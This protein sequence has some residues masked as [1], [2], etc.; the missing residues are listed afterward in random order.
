V[1]INTSDLCKEQV[2]NT[3]GDR[4]GH[5]SEFVIRDTIFN[6][7]CIIKSMHATTAKMLHTSSIDTWHTLLGLTTFGFAHCRT[8]LEP[9]SSNQ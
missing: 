4:D 2:K 8:W 6:S 7:W 5:K 1:V 3:N 9:I